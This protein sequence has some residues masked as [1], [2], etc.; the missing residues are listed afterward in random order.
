MLQ[1]KCAEA[2]AGLSLGPCQLVGSPE[3]F[4]F[5]PLC[6]ALLQKILASLKSHFK[7]AQQNKTLGGG[8][9]DNSPNSS[10][11]SQIPK[12]PCSPAPRLV[13]LTC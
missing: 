13:L 12:H 9:N 7:R 2:S 8:K 3:V 10:S 6:V 11:G 1:E 4:A 5:T